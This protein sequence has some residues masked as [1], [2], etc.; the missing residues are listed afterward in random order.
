[1]AGTGKS[2]VAYTVAERLSA[3]RVGDHTKLGASFFFKRG[4]GDRASA[5]LFFPTIVRQLCRAIPDLVQHVDRAIHNDPDICDKALGEQF[6]TLFEGPLSKLI[7]APKPVSYVV[8]VDALDQCKR[9]DDIQTLLQLW[10][11]SSQRVHCRIQWFVTS[12]PELAIQVGF[13]RMLPHVLQN[14]ALHEIPLPTIRD[15]ISIFLTHAFSRIRDEYNLIPLSGTPLPQ[16]WPGV[17]KL[18]I[19]TNIA[20]P[21]FIVAA[22]ICRFVQ[23]KYF[24]PRDQ[25]DIIIQSQEVGKHSDLGQVYLPILEKAITCSARMAVKERLYR[26]FRMIVGA[27]IIV[28]EPLSRLD[29]AALLQMPSDTI[30]LRLRPLCSVLQVP[31]QG[32]VPIRSLHLSFGEFLTSNEIDD[33]PFWVNQTRSHALLLRK[34]LDLMS[35]SPPVGLDENM[36]QLNYPGQPRGTLSK[37]SIGGRLSFALQYACRYWTYHAQQSTLQICDGGDV[38]CFLQTHF[39]HWLE[40]LSLTGNLFK[41]IDCLR[42]L[43]TLLPV[44]GEKGCCCLVSSANKRF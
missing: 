17:Q 35:H 6:R 1:M 41:V 28:A 10:S 21:L 43:Q 22:T 32:D 26:E 29:L 12:R 36:C 5:A 40:A 37:S 7:D 19:L 4:E 14:V 20:A 9:E 30:S 44:S 39:L 3:K 11:R 34:C 18:D 23:D 8:I 25:L 13:S 2:T 27:I 15:D 31:V 42:L 24:N 16:D 33:Q 38:H